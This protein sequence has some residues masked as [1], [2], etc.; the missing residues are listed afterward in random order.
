M[1]CCSMANID[2]GLRRAI[3]EESSEQSTLRITWEM[4]TPEVLH[5]AE[6]TTCVAGDEASRYAMR[7]PIER[8][9]ERK[10]KNCE[11]RIGV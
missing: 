7:R 5:G 3:R 4:A 1:F 2:F 10:G 11:E 9:Q 8:E 6:S